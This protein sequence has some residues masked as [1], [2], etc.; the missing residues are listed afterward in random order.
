VR[1]S[2]HCSPAEESPSAEG[3]VT[4]PEL[5]FGTVTT[6]QD[7]RGE[8][9]R[10]TSIEPIVGGQNR[11]CPSPDVDPSSAG[12]EPVV[13]RTSSASLADLGGAELAEAV[14]TMVSDAASKLEEVVDVATAKTFLALTEGV[15][16]FVRIRDAGRHAEQE[17]AHLRLL[18]ERRVGEL[19]GAQP[20]HPGGRPTNTGRRPGPVSLNDLGITRNE[21]AQFQRLARIPKSEFSRA[22][23]AAKYKGALSR[24]QVFR[25]C[26]VPRRARSA[27]RMPLAHVVHLDPH[28]STADCESALVAALEDIVRLGSAII[29]DPTVLTRPDRG[30][31]LRL[32]GQAA[33]VIISVRESIGGRTPDIADMLEAG[34]D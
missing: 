9:I 6:R 28:R 20:M 7:D 27:R 1:T 15:E 16:A 8:T 29:D 10:P 17:A 18:A 26:G 14:A 30:D 22:V 33:A 31:L 34:D 12:I 13:S 11:P 23:I 3:Q 5:Q 32:C 24:A 21:S 19:I 4:Q 2:S 25:D